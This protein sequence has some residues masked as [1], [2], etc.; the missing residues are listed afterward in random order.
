MSRFRELLK[1]VRAGDNASIEEFLRDY[2]PYVRRVVRARIR[3]TH[4]RRLADT[5]DFCQ[6]VMGSFL[7]WVAVGQFEIEDSGQLRGLLGRIARNKVATL[8]RKPEFNRQVAGATAEWDFAM[9]PVEPGLGP[10]DEVAR[11]ELV[12]WR[13]NISTAAR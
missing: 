2:E 3:I 12:T 13:W 7:I 5:V 10:L 6:L 8:A 9:G 4:L 11:R 1:G